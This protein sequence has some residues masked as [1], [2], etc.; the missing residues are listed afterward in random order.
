MIKCF[1]KPWSQDFQINAILQIQLFSQNGRDMIKKN[2]KL[3]ANTFNNHFADITKSLKL[4]KYPN[5]YGQSLSSIIDYFKN[6]ESGII[7]HLL[8][9]QK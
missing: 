8:C 5:C 7:F 6:N 3:I 1:G 2:E 4:K 9:F